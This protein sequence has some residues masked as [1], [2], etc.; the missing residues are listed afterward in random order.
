M[1]KRKPKLLSNMQIAVSAQTVVSFPTGNSRIA[2]GLTLLAVCGL[3]DDILQPNY[4]RAA[5]FHQARKT[6][7]PNNPS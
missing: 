2:V 6:V 1:R 3:F 5:L 7:R 4:S